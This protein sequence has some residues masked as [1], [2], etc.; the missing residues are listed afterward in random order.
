MTNAVVITLH[1]GRSIQEPC[2]S[3]LVFHEQSCSLAAICITI[4]VSINLYNLLYVLDVNNITMTDDV[5][6]F[7]YL[8]ILQSA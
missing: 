2:I 1:Y 7:R 6:L 3:Q 8:K 4:I 5:E